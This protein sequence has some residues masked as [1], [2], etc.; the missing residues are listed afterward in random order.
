M[1]LVEKAQKVIGFKLQISNACKKQGIAAPTDEQISKY[2]NDYGMDIK[3]FMSDYTEH[4]GMFRSPIKDFA[5][6]VWEYAWSEDNKPT[7]E[8]MTAWTEK[9]GYNVE[10][11]L[12]QRSIASYDPLERATLLKTLEIGDSL[13]VKLWNKFIEESAMYGEDSYIYDLKNPNDVAFLNT[14]MSSDEQKGVKHLRAVTNVRYIQ[15]LSQTQNGNSINAKTDIKGMIIAYWSDI[16]L[17]V[18]TYPELYGVF[19]NSHYFF[20]VFFPIVREFIGYTFDEKNSI[21]KKK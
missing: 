20:D 15:W 3:K 12:H 7:M 9:N 4:E 11:F 17:R 13:L 21:C 2:I 6:K 1:N 16:F 19:M 10:D 14:H 8:E 18:M 5:D